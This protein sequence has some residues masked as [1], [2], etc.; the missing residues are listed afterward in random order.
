MILEPHHTF[1]AR[2]TT[3]WRAL[4]TFEWTAKQTWTGVGISTHARLQELLG[5]A[6]GDDARGAAHAA[7]AVADDVAA[8]AEV[9]DDHA[10]QAGRRAVQRAVGDEDVDLRSEGGRKLR[11][12]LQCD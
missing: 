8:H 10:A 3:P 9:V 11:A 12:V 7:E 4:A 1:G 5:E 6:D 2:S